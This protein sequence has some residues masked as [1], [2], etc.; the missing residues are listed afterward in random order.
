MENTLRVC[1]KRMTLP[2]IRIET[3]R[4]FYDYEAKYESDDTSYFCPCGLSADIESP[5][6]AK[7]H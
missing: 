1:W 7:C 5:D 4:E 2:L 3:P 6:C